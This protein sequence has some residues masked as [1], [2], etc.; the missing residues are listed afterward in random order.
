MDFIQH[1]EIL[2]IT[3][4]VCGGKGGRKGADMTTRVIVNTRKCVKSKHFTQVCET[5]LK[6]GKCEIGYSC[7]KRHP[8][9]CKFWEKDIGGCKTK[10][11]CKYL[12]QKHKDIKEALLM[13]KVVK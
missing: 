3:D 9:I 2:E 6:D 11:L 5:F 10:E 1:S 8:R 7:Q 12:Y 13:L 4:E